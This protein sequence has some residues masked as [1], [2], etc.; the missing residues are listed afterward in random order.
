M[1]N[2]RRAAQLL[3]MLLAAAGCSNDPLA[4]FQP[5][6][7]NSSDNF[8]FQA[9]NV[10]DVTLT[11]TYTWHNTG[12]IANVNHSTTTTSGTARLTI[13]SAAGVQLYDKNLVASLNEQTAVAA[14]GD[15][16][17]TVV[18]TDFSG[19]INFRVQKP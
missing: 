6:V 18:L 13:K 10:Q 4:P 12:T 2:A 17:I 3:V 14:A 11:K 1:R 19:T 7:T 16:I 15:W 8:Q 5:E 9:T